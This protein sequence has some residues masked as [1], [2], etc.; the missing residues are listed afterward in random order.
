MSTT[1]KVLKRRALIPAILAIT[2]ALLIGFTP[3]IPIGGQASASAQDTG[4]KV[5]ALTFDDGP[6]LNG[7]PEVLDVLK[8]YDVKATF[9]L[10][11]HNTNRHPELARRIVNEG[12]QAAVHSF[13]HSYMLP[14][15][16]P[17]QERHDA[18]SARNAIRNAT[19]EAPLFYR[20][21][22][23]RLTPVMRWTISHDNFTMVKWN[24]ETGDWKTSVGADA[25]KNQILTK[26]KPGAIILLHDGINK[27]NDPDR[28]EMLKAIDSAIP[29]LQKEGYR[30]VTVS[31]LFH[32][33]AYEK[34]TN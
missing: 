10:I 28:R 20:P 6:S 11:G 3:F 27:E 9:F 17:I 15:E 13:D 22:H 1:L 18:N 31:E 33:A 7:T 23:G 34:H 26:A 12:H 14:F 32:K 16:T 19:D 5:I 29:I 25:I 2:A 8:K 4:E 21:P 30:F 24:I